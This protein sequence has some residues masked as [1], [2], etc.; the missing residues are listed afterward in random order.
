MISDVNPYLPST[1]SSG[2]LLYFLGIF[3]VMCLKTPRIGNYPRLKW[4]HLFVALVARFTTLGHRWPRT[5]HCWL[6]VLALYNIALGPALRQ[7]WTVAG[8]FTMHNRYVPPSPYDFLP[9]LY[10]FPGGPS[11]YSVILWLFYN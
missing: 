5:D 6:A 2:V 1:F 9:A 4:R 11:I 10:L 8:R 7:C 3:R